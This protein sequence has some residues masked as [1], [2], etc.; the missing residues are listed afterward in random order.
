MGARTTLLRGPQNRSK[1]SWDLSLRDVAVAACLSGT[2]AT[3][4]SAVALAASARAE[5]KGAAQ[6][7]NATSHWLY[8]EDAA[9]F[10]EVDIDHTVIGL[11][12]HYAATIF[13]AFFFEIWLAVRP[14]S[15]PS[16][17][18]SRGLGI[19]ALA[20]TVDY[21]ITPKRFTPGWEF[22]LS[23]RAMAAV[24]V[25]LAGGLAGFALSRSAPNRFRR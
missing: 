19:A 24:Y 23:K 11:A 9:S 12:T 20:A 14:T 10:R 6:P 18:A 16:V 2:I 13:W 25:A 8:G 4:A 3:V 1:T 21:T 17:I 15:T 7:L 22:V 5:G